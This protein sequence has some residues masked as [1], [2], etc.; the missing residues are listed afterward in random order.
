MD[1]RST[2]STVGYF[3]YFELSVLCYT[4]NCISPF[5]K[6]IICRWFGN[7]PPTAEVWCSF[8]VYTCSHAPCVVTIYRLKLKGWFECL[9]FVRGGTSPIVVRILNSVSVFGYGS[10]FS[11][12]VNLCWNKINVMKIQIQLPELKLKSKTEE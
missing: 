5:F 7:P 11:L 10:S 2:R 3:G 6:S 9:L 12:R 1:Y 4:Y 8:N